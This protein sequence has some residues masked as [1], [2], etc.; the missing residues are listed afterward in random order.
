MQTCIKVDGKTVEA[1][2]AKA[3]ALFAVYVVLE[4][5]LVRFDPFE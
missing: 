3:S 1:S 5:E 4:A 2:S